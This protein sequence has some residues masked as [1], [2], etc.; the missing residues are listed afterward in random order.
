MT[1]L[2]ALWWRRYNNLRFVVPSRWKL[3]SSS[4]IIPISVIIIK[5]HNNLKVKFESYHIKQIA[6]DRWRS[7]ITQGAGRQVHVFGKENHWDGNY[8]ICRVF[9]QCEEART[10]LL[11]R[12]LPEVFTFHHKH[13]DRN[14]NRHQIK[15]AYP[16]LR[17]GCHDFCE[18]EKGLGFFSSQVS[19]I[20]E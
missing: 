19:Y 6:R 10:V 13:H 18:T 7:C 17:P 15:L 16:F 11:R 8:I 4:W 5:Q 12:W 2:N 9:S 14:Q 20:I 3:I 1:K